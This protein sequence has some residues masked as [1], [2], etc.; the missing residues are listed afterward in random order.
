MGNGWDGHAPE[1]SARH[2]G[3]A[4]LLTAALS[5]LVVLLTGCVR[6]DPAPTPGGSSSSTSLGPSSAT[7]ATPTA[8]LTEVVPAGLEKYYLQQVD[9]SGCDAGADCAS[10]LVPVDYAKPNGATLKLHVLRQRATGTKIGSLLVNPGGPGGS[11]ADYAKGADRIVG[12]SVRRAFDIVGVDPRGV[13]E[14]QPLQCL[15]DAQVDA[16]LG[17]DPTPDTPAEQAETITLGTRLGDGCLAR[18]GELAKHVS[19]VEVAKDMDV[20]RYALGDKKLNYLGKSYGTFIGATYAELFPAKVGRMVL[21]GVV[22]PELTNEELNL[23]QAV[24]FETATRAYVQDCV[25]GGDCP[26]GA[27]L[28]EGMAWLRAFLKALDAKPIPSGDPSAPELTEGWATLGIAAPLYDS[29]AW[30]TLTNVLRQAK[31]G[32]GS[33]LMRLA[34]IYAERRA[35]GG[36]NDN[37]MQSIYAVNC[38]DR[39]ETGGSVVNYLAALPKFTRAAPTWGPMSAWGSAGC[40][41]WPVKSPF[42]PHKISAAG[43]ALIVVVGTTRDP[44]TPYAWAV[45]LRNELSNAA[46]IT[47]DGDG[48]TAYMR[49]NSCVDDAVS[50]YFVGDSTPKDGLKC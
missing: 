9:W 38:L 16:M 45:M 35:G 12:Q 39:P 43:S 31:N 4:R 8:T 7:S 30:P 1:S 36:Y 20:L 19:T 27:S 13:G 11:A 40:A 22:A 46:L 48:H 34:D 33:M 18:N 37:M 6:S 21:D 14:S 25:N 50:G 44:A 2:R 3:T 47:W 5:A 32:D 23:G 17:A 41:A 24:G 10:L 42:T 28:E 29:A 26:L 15:P 49:S